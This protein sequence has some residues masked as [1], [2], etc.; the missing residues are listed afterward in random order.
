MVVSDPTYTQFP[1]LPLAILHILII[2]SFLPVRI[3]IVNNATDH[4]DASQEEGTKAAAETKETDSLTAEDKEG[5]SA[6]QSVIDI[7]IHFLIDDHIHELRHLAHRII[8]QDLSR[9]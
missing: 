1:L 3:V 4:D 8:T 9:Q 7:D 6:G 2:L 5:G